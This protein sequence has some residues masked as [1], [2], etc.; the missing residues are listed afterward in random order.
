M[1]DPESTAFKDQLGEAAVGRLADALL[2]AYPDFPHAAFVRDALRGLP[3]L[4]LK[5]RVSHIIAALH[6]HLPADYPR[7]LEVI[8]AA[9]EGGRRAAV[10]PALRGFAAWPLI[11]FIGVHG[12]AHPAASLDALRH[13]TDLF[14]AEFAVRPFIAQAPAATLEVLAGF[15]QDDNEHVRRLVSEGTRPRLPWGMRLSEFQRDPTPVLGL[16]EQLRDDPALYVR[17]SVANNLND[18]SKDH[19]DL[20]VAT[21]RRWQG[22]GGDERAW[23]IR[24][25]TRGLVK[26]GHP[27][28][29]ALHGCDPDAAVE[30]DGVSLSS[31]SVA[32][33]EDLGLVLS[34]RSTGGGPQTLIVDYVVHHVKK[35]GARTP[36]VFKLAKLTLAPGETRALRRVHKL[37]FISTRVYYPGLHRV[38]VVVNG[39][40]LGGADFELAVPDA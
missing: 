23:I 29:L 31:T 19:P 5:A 22:G 10:P 27:G 1:P 16:L 21:C 18:I 4:E 11:D 14:S 17:R 15:I 25:A 39:R 30:L 6:A 2:A 26:A 12:L 7:A 20:A 9:G 32:V 40:V 8:V 28:A 37:R 24:H 3:A 35:N 34:L 33:G 36:K 38:E 13:L